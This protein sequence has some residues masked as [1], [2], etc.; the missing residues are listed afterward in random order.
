MMD[1]ILFCYMAENSDHID[2]QLKNLGERIKQIRKAKG[3][4]NYEKFAHQH[5]FNRSSY[6]R[7]ESG[8]DIRFSSL[9]RVLNA[10]DMDIQEFFLEGFDKKKKKR[11]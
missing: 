5:D 6:G 1:S 3:Y 2:K 8:E 9:L 4:S 10:F 7:F 11:K